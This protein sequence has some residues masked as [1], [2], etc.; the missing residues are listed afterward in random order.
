MKN[1]NSIPNCI[2]QIF[3]SVTSISRN[4]VIIILTLL[5]KNHVLQFSAAFVIDDAS[6]NFFRQNQFNIIF[7][8]RFV[9]VKSE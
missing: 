9:K 6:K 5:C 3:L 1:P 7:L 4:N 8:G 2:K